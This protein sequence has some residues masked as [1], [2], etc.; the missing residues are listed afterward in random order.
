VY[1]LQ[2]GNLTWKG[3]RVESRSEKELAILRKNQSTSPEKLC[4]GLP[5]E[6]AKYF[7][8]IKTSRDNNQG[9]NYKYLLRL[10]RSLFQR[11]GFEYDNVYD[12]KVLKYMEHLKKQG[13]TLEDEMTDTEMPDPAG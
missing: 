6:F 5:D 3:L 1:F 2:Q 13:V 11:Q 12:W 10:F 8:H 7:N 4:E 9:V